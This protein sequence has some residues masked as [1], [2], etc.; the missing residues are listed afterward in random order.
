MG[1]PV[2]RLATALPK[3]RLVGIRCDVS[4]S[5]RPHVREPLMR[6]ADPQENIDC[7]ESGTE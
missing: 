5:E 7:E 4:L 1:E 6:R 3:A 2:L